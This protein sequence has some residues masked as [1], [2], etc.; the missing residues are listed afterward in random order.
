M[1]N[2]ALDNLNIT[3]NP[4]VSSPCMQDSQ[5]N[6]SI[7]TADLLILG[8]MRSHLPE[9]YCNEQKALHKQQSLASHTLPTIFQWTSSYCLFSLPIK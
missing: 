3:Q 1:R 4:G 9:H 5:L 7:Q 6:H 2:M 8:N